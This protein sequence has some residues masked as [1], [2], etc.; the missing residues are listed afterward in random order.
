MFPEECVIEKVER[1]S[2]DVIMSEC[3]ERISAEHPNLRLK[4][5]FRTDTEGAIG[6]HD[7]CARNLI[8][9]FASLSKVGDLEYVSKH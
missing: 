9:S 1:S 8:G 6:E 2:L 4:L 7:V 3:A 5:Q